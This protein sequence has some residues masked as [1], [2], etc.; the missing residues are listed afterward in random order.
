MGQCFSQ[1]GNPNSYRYCLKACV[2]ENVNLLEY[3]TSDTYEIE[4]TICCDYL[5]VCLLV[6]H[7]FK[8][9]SAVCS[10]TA[11]SRDQVTSAVVNSGSTP[12]FCSLLR[13]VF[14]FGSPRSLW[15][16]HARRWTTLSSAPCLDPVRCDRELGG[17]D[18]CSGVA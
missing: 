7:F 16:H 9:R 12:R 4:Q 5:S 1:P 17:A 8:T 11:A 18:S 13:S 6:L 14:S 15:P 10:S 3:L 2:I